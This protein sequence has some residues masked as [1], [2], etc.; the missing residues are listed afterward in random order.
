MS[1]SFVGITTMEPE[2]GDVERG[3]RLG[4]DG[5]DEVRPRRDGGVVRRNGI[6]NGIR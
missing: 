3:P 6:L 1:P 5:I 4:D 2:L